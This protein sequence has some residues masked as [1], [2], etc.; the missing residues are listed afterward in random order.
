MFDYDRIRADGELCD[1]KVAVQI[2]KIGDE[3]F[4]RFGNVPWVYEYDCRVFYLEGDGTYQFPLCVGVGVFGERGAILLHLQG[5][6][7]YPAQGNGRG[8]D[9]GGRKPTRRVFEGDF[10]SRKAHYRVH[11]IDFFHC[12]V[13]KI[14]TL[15]I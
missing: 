15:Y 9:F 8:G 2:S 10:A 12:A 14:Y 6:F 11:G 4:T 5:L 1:F 3:Y 13:V 7:R